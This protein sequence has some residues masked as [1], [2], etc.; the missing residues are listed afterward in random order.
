VA[1]LINSL[2]Y[3]AAD[4][5]SGGFQDHAIGPVLGI[6]MLTGGGGANVWS[7]EDL[8][9]KIG[10]RPGIPLANLPGDVS[11]SLAIRRSSRVGAN[12][13]QPIEDEG[14]QVD[15]F[16]HAPGMEDVIAGNPGLLRRACEELSHKPV[17]RVDAGTPLVLPDGGLQVEVQTTNEIQTTKIDA[18]KFLVDGKL[19]LT[20]T[21]DGSG[22]Q[23][24]KI[25]A[26]AGVSSPSRLRVEGYAGDPPQL[27]RARTMR[28]QQ[29][30]AVDDF[31]PATQ[32]ITGVVDDG[33]I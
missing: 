26:L 2:T 19:A 20:A 23:S 22:K 17:Y 14:V 15:V 21:P 4:I 9:G 32:S 24:F 3:S 7:H 8:I 29:P 30:V 11:M 1:L 16:Y 33:N 13:G 27:V 31:D 25:P 18:V 6:S 12:V 28:L 10:P 5:F